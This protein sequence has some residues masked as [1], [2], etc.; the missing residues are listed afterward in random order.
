MSWKN[1]PLIKD[2]QST[3]SESDIN[4][5]ITGLVERTD[6]LKE[7]IV[8]ESVLNGVGFTDVGLD[9]CE[10]GQFV[11]YSK[12]TKSYMPAR[13]LWDSTASNIP[14]ESCVIGLLISDVVDGQ[15][16]ILMSGIIRNASLINLITDNINPVSGEYYLSSI[17]AGKVTSDINTV[18]FPIHCGSLTSTGCFVLGIQVP[19][20]RTHYHTCYTL[21]NTAWKPVSESLIDVPSNALYFYDPAADS[22]ISTILKALIAGTALILNHQCLI[23]YRD[24]I[25]QDGYIWLLKDFGPIVDSALYATNPFVGV[26]PWVNDIT[27]AENNNILR[28]NKLGT[29]AVI[30]TDF[31]KKQHS[32]TGK[33]VANI[34]N[35][36]IV[37]CNVLHEITAG[38]GITIENVES[39]VKRISADSVST[40]I[41][42]FNILNGN[43]IILGGNDISLLKFPADRK[44]S[45]NGIVKVPLNISESSA[46]LFMYIE[47]IGANTAAG[48]ALV[49][50]LSLSF[51][52]D[53]VVK[54]T[55]PNILAFNS[56]SA[57]NT[58]SVYKWVAASDI[59]VK[60]GDQLNIT[61]TFDNPSDTI[62]VCSVGLYIKNN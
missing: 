54:P 50:V 26:I 60:G 24:Y 43:G 14:P 36:G 28:V 41:L 13:A 45:V 9:N 39:G 29:T 56:I 30:D 31:T 17:T 23:E 10:K 3:F 55:I 34:S 35:A 11:T 21:L 47:G 12:T 59:L 61:I 37:E 46:K 19:D 32:N 6:I 52:E 62:S 49:K 53:E 42:E 38:S 18:A 57:L 51:D 22:T 7:Q 1:I 20:F 44:S 2:G 40:Q 58:A 33:A 8:N 27:V 48:S 4:P 25:I 16:T 15:G 5:I